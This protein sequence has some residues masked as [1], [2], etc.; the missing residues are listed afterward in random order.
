MTPMWILILK[1]FV[2]CEKKTHKEKQN[3]SFSEKADCI[4]EI[5]FLF[6]IKYTFIVF[7]HL[8]QLFPTVQHHLF[9]YLETLL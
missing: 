6:L 4:T 8:L 5:T 2:L 1:Y 7:L 9:V 3:D